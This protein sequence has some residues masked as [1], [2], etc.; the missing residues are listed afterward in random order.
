MPRPNLRRP[1][2]LIAAFC[3]Q[4]KGVPYGQS[5]LVASYAQALPHLKDI[6]RLTHPA[7]TT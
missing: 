4:K 7:T 1:Q 3:Q 6:G 2:A 5:S